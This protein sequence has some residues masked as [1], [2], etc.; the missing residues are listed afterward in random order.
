MVNQFIQEL[1]I[2]YTLS[3][4]SPNITKLYTHFED[5]YHIFLLMEYIEDGTLMAH[6]KQSEEFV[7][8]MISQVLDAIECLHRNNIAHRDLKPENILLTNVKCTIN[9]GHR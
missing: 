9:L 1:R 8:G 6:L 2:H 7:S 5:E 4:N 3:N